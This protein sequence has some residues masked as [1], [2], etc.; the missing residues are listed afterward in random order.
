MKKV[1]ILCHWIID[2]KDAIGAILTLDTTWLD[3]IGVAYEILETIGIPGIG[4]K[5]EGGDNK[6]Q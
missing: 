5:N 1:K 4:N 2:G 3:S 6:K